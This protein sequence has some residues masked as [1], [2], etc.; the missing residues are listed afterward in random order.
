MSRRKR[1]TNKQIKCLM[2]S[3]TSSNAIK[4]IVYIFLR[5]YKQKL[6]YFHYKCGSLERNKFAFNQQKG[7]CDTYKCSIRGSVLLGKLWI[8]ELSLLT[9]SLQIIKEVQNIL[10]N[11]CL[12]FH[13]LHV[14]SVP[15]LI[16]FSFCPLYSSY[17]L[18]LLYRLLQSLLLLFC[19]I[20]CFFSSQT[21]YKSSQWKM[22]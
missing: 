22:R 7:V 4:K 10:V 12:V 8:W 1:K 14:C 21:L 20:F 15:L 3:L 19:D 2:N 11:S 5:K 16:L 17:S 6:K 13:S 9:W 18:P